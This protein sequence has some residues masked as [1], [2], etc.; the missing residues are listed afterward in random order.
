[1]TPERWQQVARVYQSALERAPAAR[2]AFLADACRDDSDWR[3][4]VESLLARDTLVEHTFSLRAR[5]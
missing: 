1:M 5:A 2:G 3:R 4:E